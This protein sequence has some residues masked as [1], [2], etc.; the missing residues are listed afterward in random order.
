MTTPHVALVLL[1][2][3]VYADFG[4]RIAAHLPGRWRR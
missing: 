1:A 3:V 2:A 4:R